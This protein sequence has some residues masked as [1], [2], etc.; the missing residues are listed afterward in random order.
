[1]KT[2]KLISIALI[3][4][5]S[6]CSAQTEKEKETHTAISANTPQKNIRVN[7]E[8]D[9]NGN[10]IK[11]DST[12][13]TYYSNIKN[14]SALADSMY[15]KFRN[16]FQLKY[17]FSDKPFFNN[18]FFQSAQSVPPTSSASFSTEPGA[19][20]Q[21]RSSKSWPRCAHSFATPSTA[22]RSAHL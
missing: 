7:K 15:Y 6:S 11:Y 13:S 3:L 5:F 8:F 18:F 17:P 2:I 1:M 19:S 14:N 20:A 22:A 16:Q 12:Y 9:K 21:A 10:L 4:L